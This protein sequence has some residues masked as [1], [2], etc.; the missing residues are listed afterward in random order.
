MEIELKYILEK[1][2]D[3]DR[4]F[5]DG[6]IRSITD[7][8]SEEEND[9]RAIRYGWIF[10]ENAH[11]IPDITDEVRN[12]KIAE[13]KMCI[14]IAYSNMMR[15]VGGIPVLDHSIQVNE[16]MKFPRWTFSDTVDWIVDLID[17]AVPYLPW[18][19]DAL[20]D[21]RMTRAGALGLGGRPWPLPAELDTMAGGNSRQRFGDAG[22]AADLPGLA[23]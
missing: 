20:E 11:R 6:F 15:Y 7:E 19:V 16:E 17:S 22:A 5:S 4:I 23:R 13:A 14:A 1:K 10:I 8:N 18:K 9:Y 21:G 3:A 2:E 12:R